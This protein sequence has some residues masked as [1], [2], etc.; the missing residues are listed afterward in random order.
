[1]STSGDMPASK[2]RK[3]GEGEVNA[4][5]Y[6]AVRTGKIPGVYTSWEDCKKNTYGFK[7]AVCKL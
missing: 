1:M 7:G 6:Y 4:I 5:K 3:L 2:K